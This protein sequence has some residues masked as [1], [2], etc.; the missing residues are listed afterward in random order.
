MKDSKLLLTNKN[1]HKNQK[2][3]KKIKV[4]KIL[5]TRLHD[6]NKIVTISYP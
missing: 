2:K 5:K 4:E 1:N 3:D 6:F